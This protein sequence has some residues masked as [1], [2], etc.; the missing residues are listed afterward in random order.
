MARATNRFGLTFP[1]RLAEI[2]YRRTWPI[3]VDRLV[4]VPVQMS[5]TPPPSA[6][7]RAKDGYGASS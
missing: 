3:G 2:I 4:P 6:P 7:W 1:A 5:P